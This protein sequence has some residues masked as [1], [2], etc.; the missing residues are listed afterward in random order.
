MG[1]K[2][3][4]L[5]FDKANGMLNNN[6]TK[7][8]K[9]VAKKEII[10]IQDIYRY[11]AGTNAIETALTDTLSGVKNTQAQMIIPAQNELQGYV[12]FTRPQLNLTA[13]NCRRDRTMY[14]LLD[15]NEASIGNYIRHVLDPRLARETSEFCSLV[16]NSNPFLPLFSN[17]VKTISGWKDITSPTYTS[18]PGL[19]KEQYSI[20]DGPIDIYSSDDMDVTF[21]RIAKDPTSLLIYIWLRYMSNVYENMQ[22]PYMDKIIDGEIDYM[23]RMYRITT[24]LDGKTIDKISSDG[25]GFPTSLPMGQYFD[26]NSTST[27][28][29][30]NKDITVRFKSIG[31]CYNDSITIKEFNASLGIFN[32]EFRKKNRGQ[33]NSLV[34]VP[35][36]LL[37]LVKHKCLPWINQNTYQLEWYLEKNVADALSKSTSKILGATR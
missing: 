17:T 2:L 6:D 20:V 14:N 3:Q 12:F 29:E 10:S 27:Y 28:K 7:I 36:L 34:K 30:Q 19:R 5:L 31:K 11:G 22:E 32:H 1:D 26:Y 18:N 9:D 24:E 33:L 16:N 21:R 35:D 37:P 15:R 13:P 25:A 4:S 23:T 8:V